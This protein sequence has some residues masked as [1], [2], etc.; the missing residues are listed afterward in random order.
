MKEST[1]VKNPLDVQSVTNHSVG[2]MLW[3]NMREFTMVRNRSAAL[4]EAR[5]S[6]SQLIWETM[7]ESTLMRNHSAVQSVTRNS[8]SQVI[9]RN[10][11]ECT[12]WS[13]DLCDQIWY[14]KIHQWSTQSYIDLIINWIYSIHNLST[15]NYLLNSLLVVTSFLFPRHIFSECWKC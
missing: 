14:S 9:W 2:Q 3:W 6:L 1:L 5:N 4:R 11:K 15:L 12:L 8:H 10:M 13:D 7:K